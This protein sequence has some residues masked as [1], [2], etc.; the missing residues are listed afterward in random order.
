M[1]SDFAIKG[2]RDY[3]SGSI[4]FD[5]IIERMAKD[6]R[7]LEIVF[8]KKTL[9][10]CSFTRETPAADA[11]PVG[12]YRD[13]DGTIHI[14]DTPEVIRKRVDYPEERVVQACRFEGPMAAVPAEVPGF[15][16]IEKLVAVYK[17]MLQTMH[18]GEKH[19]FIFV[20]LKLKRL[21]KGAFSVRHERRLGNGFF[22]AAVLEGAE[23]L[24]GVFFNEW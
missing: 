16:F 24:G 13:R 11:V 5:F 3:L 14:L 12:K 4:I 20:Q 17:Q 21:P 22:Q 6:P 15:S 2:S 1:K 7:D 18:P 19:K 10:N 23:R 8:Y 9:N